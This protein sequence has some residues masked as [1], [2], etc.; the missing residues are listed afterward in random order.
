MKAQ[1]ESTFIKKAVTTDAILFNEIIDID[2]FGYRDKPV[3]SVIGGF[4]G[5]LA[6]VLNTIAKHYKKFD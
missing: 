1:I 2:G 4:I 5:Q 3:I 6:L